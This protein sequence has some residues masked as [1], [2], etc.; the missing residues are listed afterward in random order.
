MI[1]PGSLFMFLFRFSHRIVI[2]SVVD[3]L[4]FYWFG[5]MTILFKLEDRMTTAVERG[6]SVRNSG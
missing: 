6:G 4:P 1:A 2:L 5:A 3:S